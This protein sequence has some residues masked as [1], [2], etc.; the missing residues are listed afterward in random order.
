MAE[1][2][3]LIVTLLATWIY[4]TD[5]KP[6]HPIWRNSV[7]IV[8]FSGVIISVAGFLNVLGGFEFPFIAILI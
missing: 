3:E 2:L 7:R 8:A 6:K 4:G 5:D 1:I